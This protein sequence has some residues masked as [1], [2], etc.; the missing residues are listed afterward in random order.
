MNYMVPVTGE[1]PR[2]SV[3]G[4]APLLDHQG[5]QAPLDSATARGVA[6][7]EAAVRFSLW[8]H[9]RR[10]SDLVSVATPSCDS[11]SGSRNS[12]RPRAVFGVTRARRRGIPARLEAAAREPATDAF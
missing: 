10:T 3:Q 12:G 7:P 9:P 4:D 2:K 6:A 8:S 11:Q 5:S 1:A